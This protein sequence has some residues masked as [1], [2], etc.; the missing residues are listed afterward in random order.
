M[1]HVFMTCPFLHQK[2]LPMSLT[3]I[4]FAQLRALLA[5][6]RNGSITSAAAALG[7]T[8]P[9]LTRGLRLLEQ[10]VG[11]GL[12]QRSARGAS[13]TP[14]GLALVERAQRIEEELRRAKD[15]LLQMQ[16]KVSGN[17]SMAC[18][19][20]PMM[21]FVPE[22]I[23]HFRRTFTDVQVRVTEAVYPELMNE[24]RQESIDFAIGPIPERGLGRDFKTTKLMDVELVVAVRKGHRKAHSKSIK[25]FLE[26]DWMVMGPPDGPGAIVGQVFEKYGLQAPAT[27]LYLETVWSALEVIRHSDLIGFIPRPLALWAA[28]GIAVAP[29]VEVLPLLRIHA[30]TSKKTIL[31]PAARALISAI[32][33]SAAGYHAV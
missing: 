19:P 9:V 6:Q 7:V 14:Y 24:F 22:A 26:E 31:T 28:Q 4:T 20:I 33:A 12:L 18:S 30:I 21:L 25:D 10:Q 32:R 15:E 23:G 27:P 8:Q 16:G 5:V 11:V 29:V 1:G 17:I 13:L 2:Q 3:D